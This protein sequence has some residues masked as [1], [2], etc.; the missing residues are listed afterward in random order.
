ML[1]NINILN[2]EQMNI[3]ISNKTLIINVYNSINIFISINVKNKLIQTSIFNKNLITVLAYTVLTVNI[4]DI[5]FKLKLFNNRDFFFEL[6][7]LNN[8]KIYTHIIDI[9]IKSVLI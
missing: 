2:S 6:N 1:I 4:V 5:N 8:L 9:D 7:S 3:S